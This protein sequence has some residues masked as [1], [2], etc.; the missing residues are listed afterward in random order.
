MEFSV[1]S[2]VKTQTIEKCAQFRQQTQI[3]DMSS[4]RQAGARSIKLGT[5]YV[6]ICGVNKN[7]L[8]F[9]KEGAMKFLRR[10][11]K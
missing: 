6:S 10:F 7:E 5:K 11:V 2:P 9:T 3:V 4:L 1:I 8:F